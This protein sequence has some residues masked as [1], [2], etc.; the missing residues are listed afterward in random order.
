MTRARREGRAQC[1]ASSV[2]DWQLRGGAS[3]DRLRESVE[4][5]ADLRSTRDTPRD[6]QPGP[7]WDELEALLAWTGW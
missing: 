1:E 4:G 6:L 3:R 5:R 2:A 7:P